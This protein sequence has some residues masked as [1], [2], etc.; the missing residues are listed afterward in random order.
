ML[1]RIPQA[2]NNMIPPGITRLMVTAG[3]VGIEAAAL[4][5]EIREQDAGIQT[6]VRM[7]K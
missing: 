3:C 5:P 4:S 6:A 1:L 2:R 7:T